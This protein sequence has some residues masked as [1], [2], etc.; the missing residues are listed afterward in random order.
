M[1]DA[2]FDIKAYTDALNMWHLE[3]SMIQKGLSRVLWES[4]S[5]QHS[6]EAEDEISSIGYIL[7]ERF[8]VL[9]ETCPFP[10]RFDR[11]D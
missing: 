4:S 8:K 10:S 3:V 2:D 7:I 6:K 9:V 1:A 11:A 5:D